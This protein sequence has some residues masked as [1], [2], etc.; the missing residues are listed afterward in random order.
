MVARDVPRAIKIDEVRLRQVLTNLVG[1]AVKFTET[2]GI[3]VEIKMSGVGRLRVEVRDTGVGV[4]VQKRQDIF[5]E[6]VQADSSHARKFGGSGLGL[7]ISKRLVE[8]M[9]GEIGLEPVLEGG[10]SFWFT[11]PAVIVEPAPEEEKPLQGK[12]VAIVTR[13]KP[14]RE[15]LS[16]QVTRPA[17]RRSISTTW[18]PADRSTPS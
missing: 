1:N 10:S 13:N 12:R 8:T 7:A 15:G 5:Q 11:L 14:L 17:A 2:G 6:F 9:G 18:R 4:P 16:A 3:F